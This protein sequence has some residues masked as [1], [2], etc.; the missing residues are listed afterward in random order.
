MSFNNNNLEI[1]RKFLISCPNFSKVEYV[2]KIDILQS[3]LVRERPEVER[4]IRLWSENG[5]TKYYYT[6]KQRISGFTRQEVES[7]IT[8]LQ[9]KEL[10]AEIDSSSVTVE[11]SRYTIVSGEHLFEVD[12]YP[13]SDNYAIMEVELLSETQPYTVPNSINVIKEVT[14]IPEYANIPLCKAKAFPEEL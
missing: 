3:Y 8:P 13:F 11:K 2:N 1:E 6:E 14:G 4:R 7:E 10:Q 9:Y 12:V 5:I